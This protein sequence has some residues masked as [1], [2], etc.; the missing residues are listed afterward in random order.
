MTLRIGD[1]VTIPTGSGHVKCGRVLQ[2]TGR[3]AQPDA[4][5]CFIIHL[6]TEQIARPLTRTLR[7][8]DEGLRWLRGRHTKSSEE[9]QALCAAQMLVGMSPWKE[10]AA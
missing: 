5:A 2:L 8:C 7:Y 3:H 1:A 10:N 4:V 9:A 6:D